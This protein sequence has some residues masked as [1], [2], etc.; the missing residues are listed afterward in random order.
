[1]INLLNRSVIKKDF[2]YFLN[3]S[4]AGFIIN[5]KNIFNGNYSIINS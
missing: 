2:N 3:F 1:M 4:R 5:G